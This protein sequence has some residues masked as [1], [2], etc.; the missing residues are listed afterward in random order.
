MQVCRTVP[1]I[2]T[3]TARWP[4]TGPTSGLP[5]PAHGCR[6]GIVLKVIAP[7][8][9]CRTASPPG[10]RGSLC[11][12]EQVVAQ[13]EQA[14]SLE[15]AADRLR[16]DVELPG[17]IRWTRRRVRGVYAALSALKGLHPERFAGPPT[18]RLFQQSLKRACVLPALREIAGVQLPYLPPPL[19]FGPRP[20]PGGGPQKRHQHHTGPDPPR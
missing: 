6:A 18:V 9:C 2:R 11:A 19:G 4:V 7:S 3:G 10:F 8:A 12:I 17:A 14:Q 16:P 5:H 13:V 15:A 20:L 1:C